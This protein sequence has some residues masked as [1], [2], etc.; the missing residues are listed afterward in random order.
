MLYLKN[1]ELNIY[2]DGKEF[3]VVFKNGNTT[4]SLRKIGKTKK[5]GTKINF[6]PSKEVFSSTKFSSST[7]EKELEN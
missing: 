2:R 6:L 1:L 7:I 4:K 5:R 3:E